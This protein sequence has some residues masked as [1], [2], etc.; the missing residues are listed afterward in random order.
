MEGRNGE[1]CRSLISNA[2]M[3][4]GGRG[5]IIR[6]GCLAAQEMFDSLHRTKNQQNEEKT[7]GVDKLLINVYPILDLKSAISFSLRV[8]IVHTCKDQGSPSMS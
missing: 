8:N 3:E 5:I 4:Y 7:R 2:S 6:V 1:P